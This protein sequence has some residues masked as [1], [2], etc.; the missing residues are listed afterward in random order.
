ML[1][2]IRVSILLAVLT[3]VGHVGSVAE[4][5]QVSGRVAPG[6]VQVFLKENTYI[7][8]KSYVIGGTLIIEPGTNIKFHP[9]GRLIDSVGGRIIADG[10]ARATYNQSPDGVIPNS[11]DPLINNGFSGYADL[12]YF[13]FTRNGVS[14]VEVSTQRD[15]TINAA[16]LDLM[17]SVILNKSTRTLRDYNGNPASLG[18][19]EE[20]ISSEQ[21]IVFTASRLGP[22]AN[23]DPNRNII[24][25]QRIAGISPGVTAAQINIEG[26]PVLPSSREWGHIVILP[27]ARSAMFRNVKFENFVKDT[28]VDNVPYYNQ[29]AGLNQQ[30]LN[31]LNN[32]F[33][34]MSNGSGAAITTYSS[35]T[36]L[37]DCEFEGNQARIKGGA[38]QFLEAPE[39]YPLPGGFSYAGVGN[40]IAGDDE[41]LIQA[42][43][44]SGRQDVYSFDKN[45]QIT[46]PDGTPSMF[47]TRDYA[48][49]NGQNQPSIPFIDA[50]DENVAEPL[51]DA[52]RQAWDDGRMAI[53]LGRV[54]NL[55]FSNNKVQLAKT[56][57]E[58]V[59]GIATVKDD[60]DTPTPY[61]NAYGNGALGGAVYISGRGDDFSTRLEVGLGINNAIT[62]NG[63]TVTFRNPDTFEADGNSVANYQSSMS[64]RGARGGAVYVGD[65]TA[66]IVGGEYTDNSTSAPFLDGADRGDLAGE[67][68]MGGAI[69]AANTQGRLQIRGGQTRDNAGNATVFNG[70]SS[71]QGGAIFVDGNSSP[72]VSPVI[73]GT[74]N[75]LNTRNYGFSILFEN[76]IATTNGGA[77]FSRRNPIIRGSGGV[78]GGQ[79]LGYGG[80]YPVRIENNSAGYAGGGLYVDIPN[81]GILPNIR[82]RIE[83]VRSVFEGNSVGQNVSGFANQKDIR[84]GGAI[85]T[86]SGFFNV[87][88][89]TE[90]RDNM[91]MNGNGAAVSIIQ[92]QSNEKRFF[93]TD[94]D[95]TTDMDGDGIIDA[96]TSVDDPFTFADGVSYPVD[97]RMLTRFI[98]NS[99]M[100]NDSILNSQSGDGT[101]QIGTGTMKT[102]D[103][104]RAT[105]WVDSDM[106]YAVGEKGTI[107]KFT[108]GGDDWE[109]PASGTNG[110]INDID[111]SNMNTGVIVGAN[112]YAARTT[113]D[114]LTLNP[115]SLVSPQSA[116]NQIDATLN[117]VFFLDAANGYIVGNEGNMFITSDGGN[118]WVSVTGMP[119]GM[120]DLNSVFFF[121][122]QLGYVAGDMGRVWRTTDGGSTW[123]NVSA[124]LATTNDLMSIYFTSN[125]E[126]VAVGRSGTIVRTT[127]AGLTWSVTAPVTTF[128]LTSVDFVNSTEGYASG[129][130]ATVLKTTDA[131]A[132][133]TALSTGLPANR[134]LLDAFPLNNNTVYAVGDDGTLIRTTDGGATWNNIQPADFQEVSFARYNPDANLPE[135]GV[136]LGGAL[137]ILDSIADTRVS[138][139]DSIS[140]NRV[141]IQENMA[142]T[143]AAIY[144]DNYDLKLIF[145]RS[146]ITGNEATSDIGM[147][148][149]V[150]EGPV[151]QVNGD[152]RN[153]ASSDLAGAVIYGEIQGP[154]PNN[155][156]SEAANSIYDN[157]GR[158]LIRLPDGPNTKGL[159]A[160]GSNPGIGGTDTLRGN[161]WGHTEA[162][163]IVDI[164]NQVQGDRTFETFFVAGNGET[165][166]PFL[167]TPT[168]PRQQGP[169][170][171][172]Y[173]TINNITYNPIPLNNGTTQDEVGPNSI[174]ENL[175]FSGRIYDLYD[176]GTDIKTADYSNRRMVPIEDFAVG[177]APNVMRYSD[178]TAPSNGKY[179]RRLVRD[180]FAI[181]ALDDQG[182]V[183]FETIQN[184]AGLEFQ[185][186][187]TA[188]N[189]FYHPIG[190][191][192]YLE[193]MIDYSGLNEISNHDPTTV[194][195]TVFF[196]INE[197]TT[198]YVRVT[199]DQVGE[200]APFRETFR[201]RVDLVPDSTNRNGNTTIRRTLEGLANLRSGRDLLDDLRQNPYNED[202]A[203]LNGRR[204]DLPYQQG[205]NDNTLGGADGLLS[206]RPG[207]PASNNGVVTYF[208]GEKYNTLPVN[209]GDE[210]RIISRTVL[211]NEGITEAFN[212]GIAFR[213]ERSTEAPL[214]TGDVVDIRD[215]VPTETR[216]SETGPGT[217]TLPIEELRNTIHLKEDRTYPGNY[218]SGRDR[219]MNIT[220]V[221]VN[222]FFDIRAIANPDNFTLLSFDA[223]VDDD[224]GLARWMLVDTIN[225]GEINVNN[226]NTLLRQGYISLIGRPTNPYVV[227][228]GEDVR[229]SVANFP[230]HFRLIDLLKADTTSNRL[231]DEEIAEYIELYDSYYSNQEYDVENA[232]F[233]QQDTI[234]I[235]SSFTTDYSFKIFVI[236][237][238]P[239]YLDENFAEQTIT[240]SKDN[241]IVDTIVIYTPSVFDCGRTDDGA[242]IAN[243][244]DKLRFQI[245]INTDD[246]LEDRFAEDNWDFR[247]GRTAY[248][249]V[250]IH[251][252]GDNFVIIDTLLNPNVLGG[253]DS[254][255]YQSRPSWLADNYWKE[256]DSETDDDVFGSDFTTYGQLNVRIDSAEAAA[257]LTNPAATLDYWNTDSTMT[258][259]VNDGHGGQSTISQPVHVN[260]APIIDDITLPDA[261]EDMDY[262]PQLLNEMRRIVVSD[263]NNNDFHEFYL[264]KNGV[265][266]GYAG[267]VNADNSIPVDPCFEEAGSYDISGDN[268]PEWLQIN[269]QSGLL[270]GTPGIKDAPATETVY[271]LVVDRYGLTDYR[272]FPLN[273]IETNHSPDLTNAPLAACVEQGDAYSADILVEDIDLF[274][275]PSKGTE[276]LTLTIIEPN[277]RYTLSPS[278]ITGDGTDSTA[279]ITITADNGFDG[280]A[281]DGRVRFVIAVTDADGATDT[282]VYF[283]KLSEPTL[284]TA[285]ILIENSNGEQEVLTWGMATEATTGDNQDDQGFGILDFD[286]YCE[287]ELPP[288]PQQTI[289]DARWSIPQTEGTLKNIFPSQTNEEL[290]VYLGRF[291][292]GGETGNVNKYFPIRFTWDTSEI[293]DI[294][295]NTNNPN[296]SEWILRDGGSNGQVFSINMKRPAEAQILSNSVQLVDQ[297]AGVF[298]MVLNNPAVNTFQIITDVFNSV[299]TNYTAEAGINN[300][301]PNPAVEETT[302]EYSINT[303][304]DVSFE[305]VDMMGKVITRYDA[306]RKAV[307]EHSFNMNILSQTGSRL[308]DGMYN[309]R[310]LVDGAQISTSQITVAK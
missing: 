198:D 297:G 43:R 24:P 203:A 245:D 299:E 222:Q 192:L 167:H 47:N 225:E 305:L 89:A 119:F 196:V 183:R 227:P 150:I 13:T 221:D 65:F 62:I 306:G 48:I 33:R 293:P 188:P 300:I 256:F 25:Y 151:L 217:V 195:E 120:T 58:V 8:N 19:D 261:E 301:Y 255:V 124:V 45:P 71:G 39:G 178:A 41:T 16:K 250:N 228:G 95:I 92:P 86:V 113:N 298:T 88:K 139:T 244:T 94:L 80:K 185:P 117:D 241:E 186:S 175:L 98:G 288:F 77:I 179:V 172:I 35:R 211:W 264:V 132:T 164:Q 177:I 166:L 265:A 191:P 2:L 158:F 274:R 152:M 240:R 242:L 73:G 162:D 170:E 108:N 189:D 233:L 136:G 295:D 205:S 15:Q 101:S 197:T 169:Y 111:F 105:Y 230:P 93:L 85:Y 44:N 29:V 153:E 27:G 289:F 213:I 145:N 254:V 61:P 28:T 226:P 173:Y 252:T 304:V 199:L 157:T 210:I 118:N 147:D 55:E 290:L 220:A 268:T 142:Y 235:G 214:F 42:L 144:S 259:I 243:F 184:F 5:V 107:V 232:R 215:N 12:D 103:M 308:A 125:N 155:I 277:D 272:S 34:M 68:S 143:G 267:P 127:D 159:L 96:Y 9:N 138:R 79:L 234:F 291:Q 251:N 296:G 1:R 278:T 130:V 219:I 63:N 209:V 208:A 104:L 201:G 134:S 74:D 53:Y 78:E 263:K 249:F 40:P 123:T 67:Y 247:F 131:G 302:I 20:L 294:A 6:D 174:P 4:D 246:E 258:I 307:G 309:I 60:L 286:K 112:G 21:A 216:P 116:P 279:T 181:E 248:G 26:V 281:V 269:R 10:D 52:Q 176:K 194:N 204:Y 122:G 182:N 285:D 160:D 3:L 292:P 206:N 87:V 97:Q 165:H 70:N 238:L 163:I 114:L 76:N 100:T 239:R 310:L 121:S 271:V 231:S 260:V 81:A 54:R 275:D 282:L 49:F 149:N 229:I 129:S 7:I 82:K 37:I 69:F 46:E 146:L 56:G 224:S 31:E 99:V 161:Y 270:Y 18:P 207:I 38:V 266:I 75:T 303:S 135:N 236:D 262:N 237:S 202:L 283:V 14:T 102:T 218:A 11:P 187:Q 180:P 273:V 110:M 140:F 212:D 137:Y 66:L 50:I 154:L 84:G 64:S 36:W 168:E 148:Q 284:F 51:T 156:Y 83:I 106:G 23:N 109:Y 90:F 133:W 72:L 22:E 190:Y 276:T 223:Q 115:V 30:E 280:N 171:A 91:V 253:I 17:N 59:N 257:L 57:R 128:D 287:N 141:R 126:G 200:V 193:S 32:N